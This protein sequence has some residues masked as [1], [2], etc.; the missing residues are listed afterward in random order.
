MCVSS[1][2]TVLNEHMNFHVCFMCSL[3]CCVEGSRERRGGVVDTATALRCLGNM[4]V[5]VEEMR[6]VERQRCTPRTEDFLCVDLGERP[7]TF[8]V[9]N[10]LV[11]LV[12]FACLH[13]RNDPFPTAAVTSD[14]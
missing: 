11:F 9:L 4:R 5:G 3:M 6:L 14:E 2:H 13:G 1:L 8:P 10:A 12:L 7:L